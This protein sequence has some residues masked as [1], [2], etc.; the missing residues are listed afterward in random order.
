MSE[1]AIINEFVRSSR[2]KLAAIVLLAGVCLGVA[3]T[4]SAHDSGATLYDTNRVKRGH[5]G[6][7]ASHLY[8]Y[9][10]DDSNDN[11]GVET[12]YKTGGPSWTWI[13]DGNG[14]APGCRQTRASGRITM[15]RICRDNAWSFQQCGSW[16]LA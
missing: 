9:A 6:V 14:S 7:T 15:Y 11:W 10:C 4:A 13:R 3:S 8:V 12:Q 1:C 5:G 2:R 16:R